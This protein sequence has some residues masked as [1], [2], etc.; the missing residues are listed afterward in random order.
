MIKNKRYLLK[1]LGIK[2]EPVNSATNIHMFFSLSPL[3]E[4]FVKNKTEFAQSHFS[5]QVLYHGVN[6]TIR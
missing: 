3:K 6:A 5:F 1:T 2:C 4:L